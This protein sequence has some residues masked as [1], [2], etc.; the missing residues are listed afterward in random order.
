MTVTLNRITY[1]QDCFPNR[2]EFTLSFDDALMSRD[3]PSARGKRDDAK[4]RFLSFQRVGTRGAAR[5]ALLRQ[6]QHF[7]NRDSETIRARH[8]NFVCFMFDSPVKTGQPMAFATFDIRIERTAAGRIKRVTFEPDLIYVAKAKRGRR[9]GR[10]LAASFE[11]WLLACK[12]YGSRVIKGGSKS[13]TLQNMKR[14][15]E[16]RWAT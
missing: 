14:S 2:F 7:V 11:F 16:K 15:V 4:K 8:F 12:V 6:F 10:L 13:S 5:K 9:V 3:A 1:W